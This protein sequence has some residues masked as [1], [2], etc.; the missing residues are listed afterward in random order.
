MFP[1]MKPGYPV[2]R[3]GEWT[4]LPERFMKDEMPAASRPTRR[5]STSRISASSTSSAWTAS[6]QGPG[7]NRR[8]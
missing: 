1:R 3:K 2:H 8:G 6:V 5:G 7:R 4:R